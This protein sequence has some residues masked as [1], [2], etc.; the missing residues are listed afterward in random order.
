MKH[1]H[2][3]KCLICGDPLCADYCAVPYP[4]GRPRICNSCLWTLPL[5]DQHLILRMTD[6]GL[7]LMVKQ[8]R[9]KLAIAA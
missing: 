7:R 8:I 9:A 2:E 1:A 6:D 4:E 3:R 5:A